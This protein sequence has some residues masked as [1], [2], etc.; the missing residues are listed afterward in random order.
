[1][2][3][4]PVAMLSLASAS[5]KANNVGIGTTAAAVSVDAYVKLE[6]MNP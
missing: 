3:E 6:P 4:K 2:A 5:T 1:M